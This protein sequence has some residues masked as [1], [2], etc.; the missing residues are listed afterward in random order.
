MTTT[1]R[2]V[3]RTLGERD[4]PEEAP[5]TF[6]GS[7]F[8]TL[9]TRQQQALR[10]LAPCLFLVLFASIRIASL[11]R[12][13]I[14]HGVVGEGQPSWPFVTDIF[15]WGAIFAV[16]GGIAFVLTRRVG[17][18]I[19]FEARVWVQ[20]RIQAA[21]LQRLGR[22]ADSEL[23][24][25]ALADLGTI[26]RFTAVAP[27]LVLL[28]PMLVGMMYFL[29]LASPLFALASVVALW[30]DIG[31]LWI[32]RRRLARRCEDELEASAEVSAA[33]DELARGMHVVQTAGHSHPED[34][35]SSAAARRALGASR[36]RA[37]AMGRVDFWSTLVPF[38]GQALVLFVGAHIAAG[39]EWLLSGKDSIGTFVIAF[40]VTLI[41]IALVRCSDSVVAAWPVLTSAQERLTRL[42]ALGSMP[43]SEGAV[44][45]SAPSG[46][47]L[48][49]VA[50]DLGGGRR[51]TGIDLTIGAGEVVLVSIAR[52][53]GTSALAEAIA[54]IAR[55]EHGQVLLSGTEMGDL[56]ASER[57]RGVRLLSPEPLLVEASLRDNL[58]L[59]A[60]AVLDD[61]ALGRSLRAAGVETTGPEN[62]GL[63]GQI[64]GVGWN[65]SPAE[66]QQI[67]LAR[68]LVGD[69]HLLVLEDALSALP[70]AA[71]ED[72][73]RRV[74]EHAPMAAIAW[75][76]DA[77]DPGPADRM[78]TIAVSSGPSAPPAV[79]SS[80]IE[81]ADGPDVGTE[82][83]AGVRPVTDS[84]APRPRHMWRPF[85]GLLARAVL[86]LVLAAILGLSP[87]LLFGRFADSSHEGVGTMDG[88]ALA[89]VVIG[90][91]GAAC[92]A[93]SRVYV[94]RLCQ[95]VT[96]TLQRTVVA[97]MRG[98]DT[99]YLERA[100]PRLVA[101]RAIRDID[102][103]SSFSTG[104][105]FLILTSFAAIV[106][107]VVMILLIDTELALVVLVL[108]GS[109]AV[110]AAV[111]YPAARRAVAWSNEELDVVDA[112][113]EGDVASRRE[114]RGLGAQDLHIRRFVEVSWQRLQARWWFS[115][116]GGVFAAVTCFVA[117]VFAPVLFW[118]AGELRIA[119]SL[120]LVGTL[121]IGMLG[122]AV[123]M[124]LIT[125]GLCAPYL[126][127]TRTAWKRLRELSALAPVSSMPGA[128]PD[129]P[130]LTGDVEFVGVQVV[131]PGNDDA[132]VDA[133][134][135]VRAGSVTVL[136]GT[137]G[138]GKSSVA[139]LLARLSTPT[140][141]H[142]AVGGTDIETLGLTGYRSRVGFVDQDAFLFRGSVA[143]NIAYGRPDATIAEVESA[144]RAVGAYEIL[145]ALPGGFE[146]RVET[147]G[148]NLT[149]GQRQLVALARA[150]FGH[151]DL[152]VLDEPVRYL[153]PE[154]EQRVL[155]A[156]G[157]LPCTTLVTTSREQVAGHADAVV[158]IDHGRI[159]STDEM[160]TG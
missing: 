13:M 40:E 150:W 58:L 92:S 6:R 53:Q 103:A 118:R 31:L 153:D 70:T 68:A 102:T 106:A 152:L 123:A 93:L 7:L 90:L 132:L 135:T 54:G 37:R 86:V 113:L 126:L 33:I 121:S 51:A 140:A 127:D 57:R 28:L 60:S 16:F 77:Q 69:P 8:V 78:V 9:A 36:S 99:D 46:V 42:V 105:G 21:D 108:L 109:I 144:A 148:A 96:S 130:P 2:V 119:G 71:V 24:T 66:R 160:H 88:W 22:A 83:A 111:L 129:A 131:K 94:H 39:S 95:G 116:I 38:L 27:S 65:P 128:G 81:P 158:V 151:P 35:R 159:M 124:H 156:L 52:H 76:R 133:T 139:K 29:F 67:A 134:F 117:V 107:A 41:T 146:C 115:M 137:S 64:G 20:T 112:A 91:A 75:I 138:A 63:D 25:Q 3:G 50:V 34:A 89:L 1:D 110:V 82:P 98:L 45:P 26:E 49:G 142:I 43:T 47:E 61:E 145:R 147:A 72:T 59:G 14:D 19:E 32:A 120:G 80:S 17:Y 55:P 125:G 154:V 15:I 74:R 85:R 101:A 5:T 73:V 62:A 100:R 10:E 18:H 143:S 79:A 87:V 44:L 97:R 122:F 11:T 23:V 157:A 136:Q 141:G 56:S 149:P 48:R 4:V 30:A 155:D 114:I 104:A 12:G 84:P